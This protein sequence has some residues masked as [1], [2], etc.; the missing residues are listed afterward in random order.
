LKGEIVL[1]T[2]TVYKT[3]DP[4]REIVRCDIFTREEELKFWQV[5]KPFHVSV[6]DNLQNKNILI[7]NTKEAL[8]E[9]FNTVEDKRV[10]AERAFA[11][12]PEM[13]QKPA[14]GKVEKVTAT[15][16]IDTVTTIINSTA[17]KPTHY[18]NFIGE[19]QWIDAMSRIPRFKDPKVFIA[20]VEL[21][22]RKYLDRN[23]RKDEELQELKK[24]LFYYMYMV[25]YIQ[26][27]NTPV[28]AK[29]IHAIMEHFK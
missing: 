21:Q 27:N 3:I 29:D 15:G 12:K 28:L 25:K 17:V 18:E 16:R 24:G 20:A 1:Y 14:I 13:D 19:Y 11:W 4:G 5:T 10:A 22:V 6:F 9:W 26:N 7:L 2:Y 8:E 23:G